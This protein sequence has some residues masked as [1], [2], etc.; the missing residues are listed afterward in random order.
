MDKIC[1]TCSCNYFGNNK[2]YCTACY[3]LIKQKICSLYRSG[4]YSCRELGKMFYCCGGTIQNILIEKNIPAKGFSDRLLCRTTTHLS[5]THKQ[6]IEGLLLGDGC[7][8][9]RSKTANLRVTTTELLF[10]NNLCNHLPLSFKKYKTNG[11]TCT[12]KG[13]QYIR[14]DSYR[15]E[16]L[17]DLSLNIFRNEWYLNKTKIV[18]KNLILTPTSIRYWFYGDGSTT[19][20]A[21][22]NKTIK[23]SS[24][25]L[26]LYTNG[27]TPND[28]E[29]LCHQ[30][31]CV[32]NVTF[33]I[34]Y[35]RG[36]PIL[37]TRKY[38]NV[39]RFFNFIGPC[40]YPCYQYKFKI[41]D[42]SNKRKNAH[43]TLT[44]EAKECKF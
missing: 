37:T 12:I 11:G 4:C 17:T 14:K 19:Y 39:I 42:I 41:P 7:M 2:H 32:S 30:V 29:F 36:L 1:E 33:N 25:G 3:E 40:E 43:D 28:V 10:A 23:R 44:T 16:T 20:H 9:Q 22:D 24:V 38:D 6:I 35:Q 5:D 27:F 34:N 8:P 21:N 18:P 26:T 13:K 31:K 15:I